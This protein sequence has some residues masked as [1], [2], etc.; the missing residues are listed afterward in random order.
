MIDA[1]DI[2]ALTLLSDKS[3]RKYALGTKAMD[4]GGWMNP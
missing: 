1:K 2:S 3:A 4:C